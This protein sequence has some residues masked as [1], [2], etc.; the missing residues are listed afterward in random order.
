[1]KDSRVNYAGKI[2]AFKAFTSNQRDGERV[3]TKGNKSMNK[4]YFRWWIKA[5]KRVR[6]GDVT[7]RLAD[8]GQE[9]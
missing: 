1:M 7:E 6:Q 8:W 5:L 3:N 2:P 4:L 9:R